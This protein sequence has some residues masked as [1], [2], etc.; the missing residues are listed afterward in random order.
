[1]VLGFYSYDCLHC[2]PNCND[3]RPGIGRV[4]CK[5][6][7][8]SSEIYISGDDHRQR[9]VPVELIA[10][11]SGLPIVEFEEEDEKGADRACQELLD[12]Q[13]NMGP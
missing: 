12:D 6:D 8:G 10:I 5:P 4:H 11:E 9:K 2:H 13:E 1:M 3:P 7:Y